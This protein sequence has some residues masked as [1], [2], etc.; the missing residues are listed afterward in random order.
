MTGKKIKIEIE[1]AGKIIFLE[2]PVNGLDAILNS[3]INL[4]SE[5]GGRGTCGKCKIIIMD[6]KD[7]ITPGK[8]EKKILTDKEIKHGVR[9]ACQQIFDRNLKIFIP[10]SSL[11]EE[12]KLQ[13]E[14]E[15][16]D[17][18]V[19]PICK[20]YFLNLKKATLEDLKSDFSRINETLDKEYGKKARNIDFK[21]LTQ[22]PLAIR[23][24]SWK[25]TTTLRE[26]AKE[27]EIIFIEG[28]DKTANNYGIA[29]D[30]GTTKIAVL[31]IDLLRGET[32][33][34]IGIMNPQIAFGEDVMSRLGFAMNDKHNLRKIQKIVIDSINKTLKK[35]CNRN[36]INPQ[37]IIEM[38][39]VGNTAM[40]HLF[41]GLPVRQLAL[42]PFIPLTNSAID[43][44][45]REIGIDISPGAYLYMLPPI[46]GFVGS[47]HLAMILATRLYEQEGNCIGIDIGTNTEIALK[48]GKGIE[49]VSTAS[50]PAFEGA[51]I[52]CGMRAAPGAIEKVTINSDTYIPVIKTIDNK[53]PAGICGSGILSSISEL[54]KS[55]IIGK[56]GKFN[57][58]K[59]CLWKDDKGNLCYVLFPQSYYKSIENKE[60]KSIKKLNK[61]TEIAGKDS[62]NLKELKYRDN[63]IYINQKDIVEIQLA[64]AAI[65]TGIDILMEKNSIGSNKINKIIIAGA[66][67]YYINPGD[68][69]NIGMLPP[70]PP[71]K[72]TLVGNSA[73]VGTKMV[74]ISRK[75][76]EFAE[77]LARKI[78]YLELTT[79][80]AFS[81]FF[82]KNTFFPG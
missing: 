4:K 26:K 71:E 58:D 80:P 66:F 81:E 1:P 3:G 47:D 16:L 69:I 20:K 61:G 44:K 82:I 31:L 28:G 21:I 15:E 14:G 43:L 39:V 37:Q 25:V 63:I 29:V 6:N 27:N 53:K 78:K 50:G 9:L 77:E 75:E 55:G 59:K 56:S 64:I 10:P 46:A 23:E 17:I 76:R 24:N 51:H 54:L 18:R 74:L 36:K 70:I 73:A 34:S 45:A 57:P 19:D 33:D 30:L 42:S 79:H 48:T 5:C 38:T 8:L 32:I 62:A 13:I 65:R 35:L 60:S 7:N 68:A 22:M 52:K 40:H 67:G 11:I 2:N 72:I 49:C 41:L 12:Q